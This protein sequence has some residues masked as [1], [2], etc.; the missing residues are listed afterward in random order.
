MDAVFDSVSVVT[1]F[2]E[3]LAKRRISRQA[4]AAQAKLTPDAIALAGDVRPDADGIDSEYGTGRFIL[5]HDPEEPTAWDGAWRIVCFAQAPLEPEIGT[6][7]LLAEVAPGEREFPGAFVHDVPQQQP[8][9]KKAS[10]G[11]GSGRR[12]GGS[13]TSGQRSGSGRSGSGRAAT[14]SAPR[15]TRQPSS[16][17]ISGGRQAGQSRRSASRPAG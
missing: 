7:P 2:R 3:E 16:A 10:G 14:S 15:S 11:Q 13:G 6:D 12:S 4:L 9:Q 17:H 8:R 1:T 5:L